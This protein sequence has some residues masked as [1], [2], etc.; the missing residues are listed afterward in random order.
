MGPRD[1][2]NAP[3]S[4]LKVEILQ[5]SAVSGRQRYHRLIKEES[6][7]DRKPSE[8]L[9]R[10]RS[11]PGDMRINEV[12]L[13]R[14]PADV[15]TTFASGSQALMVSQIAEVADRMIEV[16]QFQPLPII[17][18][19]TSSSTVNEQLIKKMSAAAGEMASLK[20]QLAHL[21]SIRSPSRRC[22]PSRTRAADI[23]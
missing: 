3:Y 9:H 13:E 5:L 12:F 15:Q 8:F 21:T 19:P 23:S 18:G 20:L 1:G 2:R 7:D 14:L 4:T 17:H 6:L 11:L 10:M 16:Q 22:S